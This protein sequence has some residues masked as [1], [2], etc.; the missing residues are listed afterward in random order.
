MTKN[1]REEAWDAFKEMVESYTDRIY[2]A[3][4]M[5]ID[6]DGEER[7]EEIDKLISET[8]DLCKEKYDNM[9]SEILHLTALLEML[10]NNGI[11]LEE[12]KE[13]GILS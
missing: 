13:E 3:R 7:R 12:L 9:D 10:E 2:H 6:T 5:L 8:T 11:S 1:R 4:A